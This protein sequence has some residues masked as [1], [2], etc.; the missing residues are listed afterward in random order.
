MK[1]A[2]PEFA[3]ALAEAIRAVSAGGGVLLHDAARPEAGGY[4]CASARRIT[5]A[6]ATHEPSS[7]KML[8]QRMTITT[9]CSLKSSRTSSCNKESMRS[10]T[11]SDLSRVLGSFLEDSKRKL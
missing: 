3:E 5:P 11:F 1:P 9:Y 10:V 7:V 6:L 2:R 8:L 4:L